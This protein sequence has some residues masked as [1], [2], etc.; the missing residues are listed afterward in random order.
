MSE[1]HATLLSNLVEIS[2]ID[3]KLAQIAAERKKIET[4]LKERSVLIRKLEGEQGTKGKTHLDKQTLYAKEERRIKNEREALIARRKALHTLNNYKLQQAAEKEIEAS[5]KQL[6]QHEE[7]LLKLLDEVEA[8]AKEVETIQI[9]LTNNKEQYVNFEKEAGATL[10]SLEERERSALDEKAALLK[11]VDAGSL[12]MYQR[13][14]ERF[15]GGA[16]V[17]IKNKDQCSGCFMQQVP[18]VMSQIL[19]GDSVIKCRGCG[20]IIYIEASKEE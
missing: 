19:R 14:Q 9:S 2:K 16:V 11:K 15:P 18:Q 13:M 7:I 5:S 1:T 20:R 4:D 6:D 12:S 17:A 3:S 10:I 8:L